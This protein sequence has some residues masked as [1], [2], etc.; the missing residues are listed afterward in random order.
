MKTIEFDGNELKIIAEYAKNRFCNSVDRK[1]R[2]KD[3]QRE[4]D[5][6]SYHFRGIMGEWAFC[7]LFDVPFEPENDGFGKVDF[8]KNIDIKTNMSNAPK[9]Y[10]SSFQLK[11]KIIYILFQIHG[12]SATLIGAIGS[13]RFD[14]IKKQSGTRPIY[15]VE[16]S[17]LIGA[18]D[19]LSSPRY[20]WIKS[21]I[22]ST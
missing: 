2:Q 19:V 18:D 11:P 4:T 8:G 1:F 10:I 12:F 14:S 3:G 20:E 9:L 15:Y 6:I 5:Q 13:E 16:S 7:K 22:K 17:D 21:Q